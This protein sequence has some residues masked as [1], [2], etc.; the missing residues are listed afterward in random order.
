M[1]LVS[2]YRNFEGQTLREHKEMVLQTGD[3][4]ILQTRHSAGP[5]IHGALTPHE[6]EEALKAWPKLRGL[7]DGEEVRWRFSV[8]D[9]NEWAQEQEWTAKEKAE[10]EARLRSEAGEHYIVV[11]E[12]KIPAPWPAYDKLVVHGQRKIEHV[13]EKIVAKVKEDEYDVDQVLAYERQNLN[14]DAVIA[15]LSSLKEPEPEEPL[16]AA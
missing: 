5:F 14:R 6:F 3:R 10:Y 9:T 1:R 8:G 13:V 15:A 7:S 16:I 4:Q 11:E 2:Q 12:V